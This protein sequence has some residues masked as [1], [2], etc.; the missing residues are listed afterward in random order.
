MHATDLE[1]GN[2]CYMA[3]DLA[4]AR[5]AYEAGASAGSIDCR[6]N[7]ASVCLD[8]GDEGRA[9]TLYR[10]ALA[11]A[12]DAEGFEA[13]HVDAA[14]NLAG[15]LQARGGYESTREASMLLRD[16]VRAD[17][18]RWDAWANLGSALADAGAPKIDAI[19]CF[20]RGITRAEAVERDEDTSVELMNGIRS[21]LGEV[22]FGLGQCLADLDAPQRLEAYQDGEILLTSRDE[23]V[24]LYDGT[25]DDAD[26]AIAETAANALRAALELKNGDFPLAQNALD[27]LSSRQG[28]SAPDRASP[29]FVRA[30]FDDFAPTFDDQLQNV[31]QYKAP[32]II[33]AACAKR[34][35]YATAFD[36]GCGTGLLGPPLRS[37]VTRLVGADL[38][39]NMVDKA[40]ELGCYDS[41][42]V[43]D[44][45]D[46][47]LYDDL[48]LPTRYQLIVAADVLCY[49]GDLKAILTTWHSALD[50]GG[51]CVFSCER[52][53]G[54]MWV[55]GASGRYAHAV[56]Y[57]RATAE[58]AGFAVVAAEDIVPR[59][60]NGNDVLGTLYVLSKS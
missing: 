36:A 53:P 47:A 10:E 33:A 43:G 25:Q 16:V 18:E 9:E 48:G 38:S 52:V 12:V 29:A 19:K 1:E 41:L 56:D 27:V 49:F 28:A 30:L 57:V 7:L 17:P 24:N 54:D 13:F 45:L 51:D 20:Q 39:Q 35:P 34:G 37:S 21:S 15:V 26:A 42:V 4:G 55:L 46:A 6:V 31:L 11:Q 50:V 8:S 44:L 59:V 5:V 60:E 32:A 22:Y 58:G 2:R 40:S 14:Q 3:G 23:T